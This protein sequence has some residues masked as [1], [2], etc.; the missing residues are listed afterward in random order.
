MDGRGRAVWGYRRG[1]GRVWEPRVTQLRQFR[2]ARHVAHRGRV[3]D[4]SFHR[5]AR[6]GRQCS[7]QG[8]LALVDA[9]LDQR[10]TAILRLALCAG[11]IGNS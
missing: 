8:S 3:P 5:A 9:T 6:F 2:P 11:V 10:D 4:V 1:F 7:R